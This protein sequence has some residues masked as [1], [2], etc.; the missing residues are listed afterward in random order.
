MSYRRAYRPKQPPTVTLAPVG[1]WEIT[2]GEAL[3]QLM[4]WE[5]VTATM[6][7]RIL[8]PESDHATRQ[9]D[10]HLFAMAVR[11]VIRFAELIRKL[12]PNRSPLRGAID[13]ALAMFHKT[14]PQAKDIRDVLDHWDAYM[15]GVGNAYPAGDPDVHQRP[16]LV[17]AMQ[18]RPAMMFF[19]ASGDSFGLDVM[20]R[21]GTVLRLDVTR[22]AD[23]VVAL[24][25]AVRDAIDRHTPKR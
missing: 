6:R 10:A 15:Q 17:L 4:M 14:C 19:R 5:R 24:A 13:S 18:L 7:T 11:Q 25:D 20:P 12:A 23:A 22:D 1:K 8:D 2:I 16:D 3:G 9:G 21:L